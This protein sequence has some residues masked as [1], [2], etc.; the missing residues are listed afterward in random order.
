MC[1]DYAQQ[2]CDLDAER[3]PGSDLLLSGVARYR[4]INALLGYDCGALT[5][6]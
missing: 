5:R 3:G 4:L 2:V 1:R 6:G